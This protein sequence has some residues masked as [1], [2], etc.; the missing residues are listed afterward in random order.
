MPR[1]RWHCYSFLEKIFNQVTN[2]ATNFGNMNV[3]SE[4][5]P[6]LE[7]NIQ[8]LVCAITTLR[9]FEDNIILHQFLGTPIVTMVSSIKAYTLH[10]LNK[11]NFCNNSSPAAFPLAINLG[12]NLN[13]QCKPT[14]TSPSDKVS[15]TSAGDKRKT[16]TSEGG[17]E[18][19]PAQYQKKQ[20]QTV[21]NNTKKPAQFDMSMFWL[22]H[23]KIRMSEIFP[24]DL[25]DRV[26][27]HFCCRGRECKRELNTAYPFFH[28]CLLRNSKIRQS[29][30]W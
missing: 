1:I 21:T 4:N 2:F 22:C 27:I 19:S 12:N 16:T 9:A 20:P 28:P 7:P 8:P 15:H 5:H 25:P 24:W 13:H 10:P 29:N 14:N 17:A 3:A 26:C 30:Y 18:P 11:T 6:I 23:S